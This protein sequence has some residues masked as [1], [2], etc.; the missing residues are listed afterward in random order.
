LPAV[1]DGQHDRNGAADED[2]LAASPHAV[3][4]ERRSERRATMAGVTAPDGERA[5]CF[6]PQTR[7]AKILIAGVGYR[8]LRDLSVGPLL[9]DRLS[10]EQWPPGVDIADLSCSPIAVMH[11]LEEQGPYDR[12]LCIAGAQRQR[13]PGAVYSY[14]WDHRLP[15]LDE[16]QARVAEAVSGV[17]SLDNLLIIAAYFGKLPADVVVIE[18]EAADAGWGEGVTPPVEA[19]LATVTDI[20]RRA[21][22]TL[23][24]AGGL[25]AASPTG[26]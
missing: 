19:A 12:L 9:V 15:A 8:H 5:R 1:D 22:E 16:I 14:R 21:V 25:E 18:V 4:D 6:A 17:I 26:L 24:A 7:A 23:P 2:A 20:I 13:P 11:L 10:Q 3:P